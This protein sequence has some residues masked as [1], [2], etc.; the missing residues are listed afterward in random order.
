MNQ[1][2]FHTLKNLAID[3]SKPIKQSIVK[4]VYEFTMIENLNKDTNAKHVS[5]EYV[6]VLSICWFEH[7]WL[8]DC[9]L[10]QEFIFVQN[11]DFVN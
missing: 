8:I 5:Y 2:L 11:D 9:Y 7:W 10:H 3:V 4:S 1:R 6:D